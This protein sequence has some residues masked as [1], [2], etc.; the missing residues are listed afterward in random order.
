M[1][2]NA[3]NLFLYTDGTYV[4]ELGV[5]VHEIDGSDEEKMELLRNSVNEDY[6][7]ADIATIRSCMIG[8]SDGKLKYSSYMAL[9]RVGRSFEV[10]EELFARYNAPQN[11]LCCITP[12]IGGEP[13]IDITQGHEPFYVSSFE[14][15]PK[16]GKGKMEDFL[17]SYTTQE[18]LICQD[19]LMMITLRAPRKISAFQCFCGHEKAAN[20]AA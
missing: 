2:E 4:T 10:F 16:L 12:I 20:R 3:F 13:K 11:P 19:F 9:A 17:E 1:K 6:L 8:T 14:D 5:V 18:A 7:K 15:H